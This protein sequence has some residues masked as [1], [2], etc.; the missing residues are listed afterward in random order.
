V[1]G[2]SRMAGAF[3]TIAAPSTKTACLVG[4]RVRVNVGSIERRG[5]YAVSPFV[6]LTGKTQHG[7]CE[8]KIY[9]G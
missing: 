8:V 6:L 9:A 3:V 4:V 1:E 2:P 7:V 5:C